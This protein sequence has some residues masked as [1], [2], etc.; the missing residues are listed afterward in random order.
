MFRSKKK[1]IGLFGGSFDPPHKGHLKISKASI[2]KLKL[3]RLFWV[4]TKK[5]LLKKILSLT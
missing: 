3:D 2:K 1:L 5:I 4:V